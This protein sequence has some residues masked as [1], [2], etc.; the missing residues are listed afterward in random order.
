[1]ILVYKNSNNWKSNFIRILIL[2]KMMIKDLKSI[3][4]LSLILPQLVPGYFE[5]Y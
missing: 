4:Y 2:D 3:L 5:L 1:M